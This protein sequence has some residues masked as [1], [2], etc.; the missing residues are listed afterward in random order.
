MRTKSQ[1]SVP[2]GGVL[3]GVEH[4]IIVHRVYSVY[5]LTSPTYIP[6]CALPAALPYGRSITYPF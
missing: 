6:A 1:T 2:Q 5:Q 4:G 3:P